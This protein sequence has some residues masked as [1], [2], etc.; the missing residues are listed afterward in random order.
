MAARADRLGVRT[1]MLRT[2]LVLDRS[3]GMLARM[4][5]PF[6]YGLGGPFGNG[7]QWMSWIHRD[8]LVRLICHAIACDDLS[9]PVNATAP[10][11]VTNRQFTAILAKA[12]SRPAFLPVPAAPLRLALGAFAEELLLSGQRVFPAKAMTNGFAFAY[13]TLE[14]AIAQIVGTPCAKPRFAVTARA[15]S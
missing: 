6:E 1:V 2:G 4:L 13:P 9:G 3:G 5:A 12:L 7:Q 10:K 11:A 8:D 14:Q 15:L